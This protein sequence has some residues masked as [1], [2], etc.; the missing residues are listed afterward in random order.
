VVAKNGP[1][2]RPVED[3]QGRT[4]SG[5]GRLEANKI[6]M[7][8]LAD[9]LARLVGLPVIDST[10][11][12]GVFDF[13]LQWSPDEA[14]KMDGSETAGVA[15]PSIFTALEEQLGLKL[16]REK[17]PVEILIV[18]RIEKAPTGN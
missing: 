16:T 10:G 18:D 17:G 1:K 8:K 6:A 13:T 14:P 9:L 12:K 3:G 4:S 11:A 15:G 5:P 2:I 7:Q